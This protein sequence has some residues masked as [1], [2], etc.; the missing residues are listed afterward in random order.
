MF[1]AGELGIAGVTVTLT[2]TDDLGNPVT[3]TTTTDADGSYVFTDLRPGT[4]A[5]TETQPAGL[6]RRHRQRRIARRHPAATTS[7]S[8]IPLAAGDTGTGYDFGEL[9]AASVAGTVYDDLEPTGPA[10]RG[11]PGI[12]GVTVDVDRHRRSRQPGRASPPPPPQTAHGASPVCVPATTRSPRPSPPAT[13][14]APT[15]RPPRRRHLGQRSR[16]PA[17][18]SGRAMSRTG[19]T[20]GEHQPVDRSP[21][22]S[23]TTPTTTAC[24]MRASRASAAIEVVLFG[25]D[26]HGTITDH[27]HHDRRERR[28]H[29]HRPP[30]LRRRRLHRHRDPARAAGS[31][32]STPQAPR[33]ATPPAS[34]TRSRA[35]WWASATPRAPTPLV[36]W[37]RLVWRVRCLSMGTTTG[38]STSPT[39]VLR[40]S[41]SPSPAPTTSALRST[42]PPP[43][44]QTAPTTSPVCVPA[45][46]RSPKPTP[47]ATSTASTPQAPSAVSPATTSSRRSPSP[48]QT[49]APAT[50]SQS[51]T[52][53]HCPASCSPTPTTTASKTPA[54][55]A[56]QPSPSPSPAPTT[57]ALRSTSPPPP[58]ADGTYDFTNLR[59]GT[60][61]VTE[62]HPAGYLDGIDTAGTLGGVAGNDVISTITVTSADSGTG[63]DF[64]ELDA[65]IT[66]RC[67]VRRHQQQRCHRRHRNR[68]PRRHRHP[69]RHRR[70]RH[71]G[72]RRHHHR[73]RRRLRLHQPAARHLHRHR[74]PP[75]RLPRRHRHRRHRRRH[76]RQRHHHQHH[77]HPRPNRHRIHL[78]RA[79]ARQLCAAPS[80]TT[81]TTMA[82]STAASSASPE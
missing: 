77:P 63:Y 2:G 81:R 43:P 15:G 19:N 5:V 75:H 29:V 67:R 52:P 80:T 17:S 71:S 31:T 61:T 32:A 27:R 22:P 73:P 1:D 34:T 68:H 37:L 42:S 28:L 23:T 6:P 25:T 50:T 7:F 46:T 18:S 39:P 12:A 72:Q 4:Y 59:P 33:V 41:R 55:P 35:S 70:P 3:L 64:A 76:H 44:P 47:P 49:P 48:P 16:S 40:A 82:C 26:D 56:S 30:P 38:C 11:E 65:A 13:S 21:A 53:P 14:T 54:T 57:S 60:Y 8:A 58:T 9:G 45:T 20:F 62:T 36:S 78:R 51:S 10:T 79:A 69:H 66:V 24:E 74:N